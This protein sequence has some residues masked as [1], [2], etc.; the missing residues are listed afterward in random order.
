M[1]DLNPEIVSRFKA[2]YR[3]E[4]PV[5][6]VQ[7]IRR[8]SELDNVSGYES[9]ASRSQGKSSSDKSNRAWAETIARFTDDQILQEA[10][11]QPNLITG[12]NLANGYKDYPQSNKQRRSAFYRRTGR[13]IYS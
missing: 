11:R 5:A 1:L 7:H 9:I 4:N 13:N 8:S 2:T 3:H 6:L 10:M 12:Y